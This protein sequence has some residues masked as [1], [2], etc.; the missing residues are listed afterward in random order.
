MIESTLPPIDAAGQ[1]RERGR[2]VAAFLLSEARSFDIRVGAA[3][4]ASELI[5]VI[6][7]RAPRDVACWFE[8]EF[9]KHQPAIIEF[10]LW[11]NG[12]WPGASS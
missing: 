7:L 5:V 9:N 8:R 2:R 1:E 12:I 10:I 3:P 4:D 6:P 11:Q